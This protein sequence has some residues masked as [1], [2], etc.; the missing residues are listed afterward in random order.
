MFQHNQLQGPD[1]VLLVYFYLIKKLSN[2]DKIRQ[3]I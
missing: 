2:V 1:S 3:H